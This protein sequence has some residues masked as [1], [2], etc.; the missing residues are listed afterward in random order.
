MTQEEV[1][2]QYTGFR[3]TGKAGY[4]R[5]SW[6]GL[7]AWEKVFK[8]VFEISW[9][10]MLFPGWDESNDGEGPDLTNPDE[11]TRL[12]SNREKLQAFVDAPTPVP[13]NLSPY[14]SDFGEAQ[15]TIIEEAKEII[16]FIDLALSKSG[17]EIHFS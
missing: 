2:A 10:D 3:T 6:G 17:S 7:S 8:G 14:F 4:L 16:Y 12:L 11:R 9:S 5:K 1:D 15:E 13:A